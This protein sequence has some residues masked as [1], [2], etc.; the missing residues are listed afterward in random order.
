M[1][2]VLFA[3]KQGIISE[4]K[5]FI[6]KNERKEIGS[7]TT[8]QKAWQNYQPSQTVILFPNTNVNQTPTR[9]S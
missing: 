3:H 1:E 6:H 7:T 2:P 8:G 5:T 9:C 4:G